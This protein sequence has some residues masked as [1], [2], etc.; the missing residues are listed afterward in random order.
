MKTWDITVN[1]I[2]YH[3]G[4]TWRK[5]YINDEVYKFSNLKSVNKGYLFYEHYLPIP[6]AEVMLTTGFTS[7]ELIVDGKNA[8]TGREYHL[9]GELPKWSWIFIAIHLINLMNG[10]IGGLFCAIGVYM[11]I[12]ISS[13]KKLSIYAKIFINLS[14]LIVC[15]VSMFY[16]VFFFVN[17]IINF[18]NGI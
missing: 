4:Y 7:M 8:K 16:F 17:F 1:G 13:S 6:G 10:L 5:V 14:I 9:R 15:Y 2:N 12:Y 3:I 11:T 18:I